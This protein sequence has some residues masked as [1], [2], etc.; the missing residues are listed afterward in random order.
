MAEVE[1]AGR[2]YNIDDLIIAGWTGRD[3]AALATIAYWPI[4]SSCAPSSTLSL[5]RRPLK[6]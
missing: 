2:A 4:P 6:R 5:R 3:V 1:F